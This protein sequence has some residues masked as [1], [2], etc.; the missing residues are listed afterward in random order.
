MALDFES[1]QQ[2][3]VHPLPDK[4][5]VRKK[6]QQVIQRLSDFGVSDRLIAN[7]CRV[8][9]QTVKRWHKDGAPAGHVARIA[10]DRLGPVLDHLIADLGLTDDAITSFLTQEPR[11]IVDPHDGIYGRW[12]PESDA[13]DRSP[14][15][16]GIAGYD[17]GLGAIEERLQLRF[18]ERY[19]EP[20][21]GQA[22]TPLT[23]V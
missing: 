9:P 23:V 8:E 20:H 5:E 22:A 17:E 10:I 2:E 1:L 13:Y 14:I 15:I 16:A 3:T 11:R 21:A 7:T 4:G 12:S 18:P 19:V 6:R